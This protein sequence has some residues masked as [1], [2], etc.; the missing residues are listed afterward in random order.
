MSERDLSEKELRPKERG[1]LQPREL[2]MVKQKVNV[3]QAYGLVVE[4]G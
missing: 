4:Y 2:I 3:K 1:K